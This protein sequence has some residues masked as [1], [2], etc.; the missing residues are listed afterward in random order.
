LDTDAALL[1]LA[2]RARPIA[3]D[4][5]EGRRCCE[6]A[7]GTAIDPGAFAASLARLLASGLIRD[8][9]RLSEGDLHCHFVLEATPAGIAAAS[10]PD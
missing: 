4:A 6:A 7:L 2:V 3:A 5:E 9:V 1:G 8:P 10:P